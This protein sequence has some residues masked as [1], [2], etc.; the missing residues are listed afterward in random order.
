[1]MLRKGLRP[2]KV[3]KV[4]DSQASVEVAHPE[5]EADLPGRE[6]GPAAGPSSCLEAGVAGAEQPRVQEARKELTRSG[7]HSA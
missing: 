6:A 1:M 2:G 3:I 5:A 7:E 4:G